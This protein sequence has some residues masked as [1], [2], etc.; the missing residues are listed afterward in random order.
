MF[1]DNPGFAS[2]FPEDCD[3]TDPTISPYAAEVYYDSIDQDCQND[4]D[5]DADWMGMRLT[6]GWS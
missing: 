4:D 6:H 2:P 5:F 3:D 1:F